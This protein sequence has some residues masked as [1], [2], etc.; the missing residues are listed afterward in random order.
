MCVCFKHPT[1]RLFLSKIYPVLNIYIY[2]FFFSFWA[3]IWS[4][5]VFE[6]FH[7]DMCVL[8]KIWLDRI[9]DID[10]SDIFKIILLHRKSAN[11]SKVTLLSVKN[12]INEISWIC[13]LNWSHL[14][15]H[16]KIKL[17]H[18]NMTYYCVKVLLMPGKNDILWH[19]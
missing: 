1:N 5:T 10:P 3:E 13:K 9:P 6:R 4:L 2:S 15:L 16:L 14:I 18:S 7:P 11:I 8:V 12:N 17:Y 19:R